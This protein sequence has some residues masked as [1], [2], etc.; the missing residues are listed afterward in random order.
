[1]AGWADL[2][3]AASIASMRWLTA[4]GTVAE[5]GVMPL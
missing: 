3:T 2:R 1:M 5:F 4:V